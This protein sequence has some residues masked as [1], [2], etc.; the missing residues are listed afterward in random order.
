LLI[1][2]KGVM[3]STI[4]NVFHSPDLHGEF[5]LTPVKVYHQFFA[6]KI[7]EN[8]GWKA[9][10]YVLANVVT[11]VFAYSILGVLALFG[12]LIKAIAIPFLRCYNN[13]I[14][15][16]AIEHTTVFGINLDPARSGSSDPGLESSEYKTVVFAT[17][18]GIAA[19]GSDTVKEALLPLV[20]RANSDLIKLHGHSCVTSRNVDGTHAFNVSL[21]H[22]IYK[23]TKSAG[24]F[25]SHNQ[26]IGEAIEALVNP[27]IGAGVKQVAESQLFDSTRDLVVDFETVTGFA[28][29][30]SNAVREALTPVVQK[31]TEQLR[32]LCGCRY[33]VKKEENDSYRFT[34]TLR[35]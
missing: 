23:Q 35:C 28:Q 6:E 19:I 8:S 5:L 24:N 20:K 29:V 32:K 22:R 21:Y 3:P 12:M 16:R 2:R 30:G 13:K 34:I 9:G 17:S 10:M 26:Q 15:E 18:E 31:A 33:W 11:G 25:R 7:E 1:N 14:G 4:L 27:Y